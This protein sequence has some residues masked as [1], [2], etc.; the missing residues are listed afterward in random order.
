LLSQ[1]RLILHVSE[2]VKAARKLGVDQD[3]VDEMQIWK[4]DEE[5]GELKI[6]DHGMWEPKVAAPGD[7]MDGIE[8]LEPEP[9]M[10]H[11]RIYAEATPHMLRLQVD[12]NDANAI[13]ELDS[14]NSKIEKQNEKYGYPTEK[15][16]NFLINYQTFVANYK[17]AYAPMLLLQKKP[18][19]VESRTVF[20]K[21]NTTL[22]LFSKQK[23]Y[24]QGWVLIPPPNG[25]QIRIYQ[26]AT[27]YIARIIRNVEDTDALAELA[28]I[29]ERIVQYNRER[30]L[31]EDQCKNGVID[32]DQILP[33]LKSAAP[34]IDR[35]TNNS[36]DVE[37]KT[38]FD[39]LNEQ[40]RR[41]NIFYHYPS[42]WVMKIPST[43]VQE[44]STSSEPKGK[45]KAKELDTPTQGEA[46]TSPQS[47]PPG[48][49]KARKSTQKAG[50]VSDRGTLWVSDRG[51][52]KEIR[53][54]RKKGWGHQ[55][56]L[57][58]PG[59]N[60]YDIYELV[61][62]STFGKGCLKSYQAMDGAI[63]LDMTRGSKKDLEGKMIGDLNFFGVAPVR[64]DPKK[65]PTG[66]WS[67]EPE[68]IALI[69]FDDNP[70]KYRWY[71]RSDLIQEI[72]PVAD[73]ELDG[74]RNDAGQ[75]I[76]PH[77]TRHAIRQFK[78]RVYPKVASDDAA[79]GSQPLE[80]PDTE[81]AD[82]HA[83]LEYDQAQGD[84]WEQKKKS[85]KA[86]AKKMANETVFE[87]FERLKTEV[88]M[89][90]EQMVNEAQKTAKKGEGVS[91]RS[92]KP[93]N[94]SSE[95]EV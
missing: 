4:G 73:H 47:R 42:D 17:L 18:M 25:Y 63:N 27:P 78:G 35:L 5:F 76:P 85:Q 75:E 33:I 68:T 31:D 54:F 51:T 80:D 43:K 7:N 14:L 74:Y 10:E 72:G 22:K 93:P 52:L 6:N 90:A 69:S 29:N 64:R 36:A 57:H 77:P 94:T 2:V 1:I 21:I 11:Q 53:G 91:T 58:Q 19:D 34:F 20:D 92:Q 16:K 23:H 37:A 28:K 84:P 48:A 49:P 86:W 67:R 30:K 9:G 32:G 65:E 38:S 39:M 26:E 40:L 71:P 3:E 55:L 45:D 56:L 62:A 12:A 24:P 70:T 82:T 60:G 13:K 15:R 8:Q 83:E 41:L 59:K 95:V 88:A 79:E 61:A 89:L 50:W 66:G 81:Y 44:R 87:R 46:S